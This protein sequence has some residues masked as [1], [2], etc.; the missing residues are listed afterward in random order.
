MT[1][2]ITSDGMVEISL[3]LEPELGEPLQRALLR[4]EKELLDH[5]M[6]H[7]GPELRTTPQRMADAF[8]VITERLTAGLD[9]P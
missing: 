3:T 2:K 5:D 8:V 9:K 4:I 1:H 7:G 6:A